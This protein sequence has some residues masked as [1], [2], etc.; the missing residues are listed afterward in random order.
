MCV[1][2]TRGE[3]DWLRGVCQKGWQVWWCCMRWLPITRRMRGRWWWG[4][5]LIVACGSGRWSGPVIGCMRSTPKLCP[6]TGTVTA[7]AG[8]KSDRGD[9]KVLA[10]LVRAD[11]HNHRRVAGDSPGAEGI[12]IVAR[13]YQ[14]LVWARVRHTNGVRNALR[15]YYPAALETFGDLADRD[16]LAILGRAPTPSQGTRLTVTQIRAA[17]KTAG[18]RRTLDATARKIQQGSPTCPTRRTRSGRRRLR[19]DGRITG[20]NHCRNQPPDH[21]TRRNPPHPFW[22]APGRRC[23]PL[24]APTRQTCSAPGR[25]QSVRGSTPTVTPAPSHPETTPQRRPSPSRR[26]GKHAVV[27]RHVRKAASLRRSRPIGGSVP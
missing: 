9:A 21:R 26:D 13:A 11:R 19:D 5:R 3:P 25:S 2:W 20:E 15:E 6:A 27:A 22:G 8:A 18:R 10:D 16:T 12:K 24:P 23:I 4:S 1:W 14:N 17:L 7:W